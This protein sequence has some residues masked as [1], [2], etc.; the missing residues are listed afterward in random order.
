M[1]VFSALTRQVTRT[2]MVRTLLDEK[3][4]AA[5]ISSILGLPSWI[6]RRSIAQAKKHSAQELAAAL[7]LAID[8]DL[9]VKNGGIRPDDALLK[10]TLFLTAPSPRAPEYARRSQPSPTVFG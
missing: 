1:R 9:L 4:N 8:L 10:L 7:D 3:M 6:I 5:K 2:L